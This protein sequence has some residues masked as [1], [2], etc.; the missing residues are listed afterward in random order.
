MTTQY[1]SA[2]NAKQAAKIKAPALTPKH[3]FHSFPTGPPD[4][5]TTSGK[6]THTPKQADHL[7]NGLPDNI[8]RVNAVRRYIYI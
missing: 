1:R 8:E 5:E 2:G 4:K 3:E 6:W 7:M